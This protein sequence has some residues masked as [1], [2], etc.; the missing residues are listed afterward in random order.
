MTSTRPLELQVI[1]DDLTGLFNRRYLNEKLNEITNVCRKTKDHF[2]LVMLDMD[3]FKEVNDNYGHDEGDKALIWISE[4]LRNSIRSEDIIIRFAGDEFFLI[5]PGAGI[6][7]AHLVSER[8][9]R[10]IR[11]NPFRGSRGQVSVDVG[12]SGGI[13]IFPDDAGSVEEIFK[14]ADNGLYLAKEEGT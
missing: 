10:N 5:L 2:A 7:E 6:K 3:H 13:A 8:I 4:I 12:I 1:T 11:S 9:Y 14:A